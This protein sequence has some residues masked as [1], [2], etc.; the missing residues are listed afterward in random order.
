M[1]KF[2]PPPPPVAE[3]VLN[4]EL[5][6]LPPRVLALSTFVPPAPTVTVIADPEVTENPEA[7]R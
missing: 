1:L 4:A 3:I 7:F 6:P 5:L 2:A